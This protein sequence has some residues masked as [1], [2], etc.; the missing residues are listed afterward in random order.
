MALV[1][2]LL[3]FLVD[4]AHAQAVGPQGFHLIGT[5]QSNNFIGAVFSD[6]KGEQT[7]ARVFDTLP[8]GSQIVAV[9]SDSI[10]LKRTDGMSYDMYIA[11]DMIMSP[12]MNTAA[13]VRPDVPSDPFAPGT[14]QNS[15]A[16]EPKARARPHGRHGRTRTDSDNE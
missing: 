9:R 6:P 1:C 15:T 11:H 10:S 7:F 2:T 5:I 8:D 4:S 16:E 13:P 14:L 3:L 12:V